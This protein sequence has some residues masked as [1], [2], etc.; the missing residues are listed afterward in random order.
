MHVLFVGCLE[1]IS[2]SFEVGG[3]MKIDL[4]VELEDIEKTFTEKNIVLQSSL[5]YS[6]K[7]LPREC[8]AYTPLG[9][10]RL[11]PTLSQ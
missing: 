10:Q 2:H 3:Y 8:A 5:T 11:D 1:H 4:A 9:P 6:P 7:Y